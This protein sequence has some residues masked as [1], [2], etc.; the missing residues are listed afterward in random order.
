[1]ATRSSTN[2]LQNTGALNEVLK[3]FGSLNPTASALANIQKT[4]REYDCKVENSHLPSLGIFTG[5]G[6]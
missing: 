1:M 5:Q 3:K 4:V 6:P 2:I